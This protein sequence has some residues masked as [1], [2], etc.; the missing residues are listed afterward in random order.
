M[1]RPP[2]DPQLRIT[3]ILNAA[4]PLFY[5]KGYQ[6]TSISDI[7]TSMGVAHGT[8]YYYF[9]SKEEILEALLERYLLI[10]VA[11]VKTK[12]RTDNITPPC[13]IQLIIQILLKSICR[14]KK[15]LFEFL[16]N[17]RT[18]HFLDKLAR[19][20]KQVTNLLFLETIEEG[21]QKKYF[22]TVHPQAAVNIIQAIMES[23]INALYEKSSKEL[24]IYQF[25]LAE[26]LI[27]HVLGAKQGTIAIIIE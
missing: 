18:I 14:D 22:Q 11:E 21:N 27:E 7:V 26:E 16:Y 8:I 25:K 4:E 10:F 15:L 12:L 9:K 1:A 19:Q 5:S 17:D 13:K 23:L 6:E 3:E 24:L 2:Q 20:G